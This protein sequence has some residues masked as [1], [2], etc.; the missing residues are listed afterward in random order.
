M[1]PFVHL[2]VHSQYS[3]LDGLASIK[4][5]VDKAVAYGMP[6]MAITDHANM[7]GIKDFIDYVAKINKIR[8]D[9]HLKPFIPIAG[10]EM[11]VLDDYGI[12]NLGCPLTVLAKNSK[13]YKNLIRLVSLSWTEGFATRPKVTKQQLKEHS[14]GLIICSG[15]LEGEVPALISVAE[16]NKAEH[17]VL[18]FK[19]VFGND[20]YLEIQ[21]YKTNSGYLEHDVYCHQ[22]RIEKTL[23]DLGNKHNIK[24]VATNDVHFLNEEDADAHDHL[25]CIATDKSVNAPRH[26]PYS[27][28]EWLKSTAEMNELFADIP[29]CLQNTMEILNKVDLFSIDSTPDLP[30]ILPNGVENEDDYL[31]QL[32]YEGA[33]RRWGKTLT[34]EQKFRL[35][36]E[37]N[38][39][40]EIGSSK[41]FIILHDLVCAACE[42]G[43][44]LGPGRGASA[45]LA[46]CYCLGITQVDPLKFNLLLERFLNRERLSLPDIDLDLDE[47]GRDK[48]IS[49]LVDKYGEDKVAGI[50]KFDKLSGYK[51][52][53][54]VAQTEGLSMSAG[55]YLAKNV[56]SRLRQG[57]EW[58]SQISLKDT[59]KYT[60][61]ISDTDV[62]VRNTLKYAGLLED[63]ICGTEVHACGVVIGKDAINNYAPLCIAYDKHADKHIIAT[64]YSGAEIEDTGLIKLD[65]VGLKALSII[66]ETLDAIKNNYGIE[67]DIN[68]IPLN[69]PK[70]YQLYSEGRTSGTFLFDY[71]GMQQYLKQL[72][73]QKFDE[74]IAL[75]VLYRPGPLEYIPEY[76]KRKNVCEPVTYSIPQMGKYLD[77]TYGVLV[78]QEQLRLLSQ[79]LANF[80][81][82]ES[83][84]L[85]KVMSKKQTEK[86]AVLKS[87]FM[88]GGRLNGY[89]PKVLDEIWSDWEELAPYT[90]NK[91]HAVCYTLI[92][93]QTAWL[94]VNYPKEF[95]TVVLNHTANDEKRHS[96]LLK[97]CHYIPFL[98]DS[99]E[100]HY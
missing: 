74:L 14:E 28:Q 93:Y 65:L 27:G 66:K 24:V 6:G 97:E 33:Y 37:L 31:Y 56:V 39:I 57:N 89:D 20:F 45:S 94:K 18:W 49:Y 60:D 58:Y 10:C 54:S 100:R 75:N 46:V 92:A 79:L 17:A 59:E 13:G 41:Y 29:Q 40:K 19:E 44:L 72:R 16:I 50:I 47:E 84:T 26:T 4:D 36:N 12:F 52:I 42:K 9:N 80:T 11:Y 25:I 90:F 7:M 2:H 99:S 76:I 8:D 69:D 98:V 71:E 62:R 3:I 78:Y 34:S 35:E 15:C 43:V 91:S 96:K 63:T 21:R 5:L 38:L 82:M 55:M 73:P 87:K 48:M 86:L 70:T 1:I 77:E 81:P 32:V 30:A 83:D 61:L 51:A 68:N 85:R 67:V 22:Q 64:Q 95:L 88:D 53:L 23:L